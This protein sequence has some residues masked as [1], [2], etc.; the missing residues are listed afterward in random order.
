[1]K[2]LFIDSVHPALEKALTTAGH[3]CI[4]DYRSSY[5]EICEK[6][7]GIHGL[8]VRSR[9]PIDSGLICRGTSLRFIAR[10]GSGLE[11]IDMETAARHQVAVYSSPEGNRDAVGEHALGMLLMLLNRLHLA[12]GEVQKGIWDRE[13]NRGLE[14]KYLT[15]GIIGCGHMGTAFAE[16]LRGLGCRIMAHDK[17]KKQFAPPQ[18]EEV[19]LETMLQ[20]ADVVSLHLPLSAETMGYVN[21]EFI[22][23]MRKPFFLINTARGQHVD[24]AALV[25][26]LLSGKVRGACLDVLE[27]E[28]KS[29]ENLSADA[30]PE[31]FK[32]LIA[33]PKVVLSPHVAGW[34]VESYRKLAEVLAEKILA[35]H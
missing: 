14:L 21:A 7:E 6:L 30:L 8:V 5:Q 15:V 24:T 4:H 3:E 23:A 9:I 35:N 18:V 19:A 29:F 33:H 32:Q 2:V 34:T 26:G 16:K 31:S 22:A 25:E 13:A 28:K 12:H 27:F 20:E 10:S 1:M 11:N 17:Y